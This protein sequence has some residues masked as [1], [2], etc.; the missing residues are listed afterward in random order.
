MKVT[1]PDPTQRITGLT[2]VSTLSI[3]WDTSDTGNVYLNMLADVDG[4]GYA[5]LS[6]IFSLTDDGSYDLEMILSVEDG[7]VECKNKQEAIDAIA[8]VMKR[9]G[10]EEEEIKR[11]TSELNDSYDEEDG[12]VYSE[13]LDLHIDW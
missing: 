8:D 1:S 11:Y 9:A 4:D 7:F 12:F 6:E 5:D 10:F 2:A 3:E 13:M